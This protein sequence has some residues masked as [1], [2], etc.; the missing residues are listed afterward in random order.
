MELKFCN[1]AEPGCGRLLL[2]DSF[3]D[4]YFRQRAERQAELPAPVHVRIM[5][6]P[7]CEACCG[8]ASYRRSV[9]EILPNN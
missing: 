2:G 9:H 4:W 3:R 8:P 1:C 6:R 7:Y 5:G